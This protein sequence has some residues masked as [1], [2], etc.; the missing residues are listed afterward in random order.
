MGPTGKALGTWMLAALPALPHPPSTESSAHRHGLVEVRSGVA[1]GSCMD[2]N[3]AKGNLILWSCHGGPNQR[4]LYG[5]DG[6]LR[7]G[8]RCLGAS[9]ASLVLKACDASPDTLW[10]FTAGEIRNEAEQCIDIAGGERANG[11]PLVAWSCRGVPQQ[12]WT[13]R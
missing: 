2:A 7:Q 1:S 10:T 9:G 11:T 6:T 13:R 3:A 8:G 12:R 5:D 4:F